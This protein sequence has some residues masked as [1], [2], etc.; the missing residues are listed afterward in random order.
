MD[1]Y[2]PLLP[3]HTHSTTDMA[4]THTEMTER[5]LTA[6]TYIDHDKT[7]SLLNLP[8]ELRLCIYE[9]VMY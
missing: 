5:S 3:Q 1:H 2:L 6:G 9:F 8:P 4:T 7:P